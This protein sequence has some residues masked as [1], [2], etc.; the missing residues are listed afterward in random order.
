MSAGYERVGVLEALSRI[1]TFSNVRKQA[2]GLIAD[3]LSGRI[4]VKAGDT[5]CVEGEPADRWWILMGGTATVSA[6]GTNVGTI[7]ANDAVGE[8]AL[9]DGGNRSATITA[10]SD[11]DVL[12]FDGSNF[13]EAVETTPDLALR[14]LQA[15]AKRLREVNQL[16]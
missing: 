11:L 14:M 1:E 10:E 8:L 16:I 5:L 15:A 12:V 3:S 6:N 7:G 9:F 13:L 4:T 2:L